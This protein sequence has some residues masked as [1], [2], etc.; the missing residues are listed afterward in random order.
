MVTV[1]SCMASLQRRLR[2]RRCAIDFVRQQHV[3]KNPSLLEFEL[4]LFLGRFK[5]DVRSQKI[6]RH[7]IGRKLNST[8]FEVQRV[9]QCPHQHRLAQ[10]RNAL[11]QN[12]SPANQTGQRALDDFVVTDD[13]LAN[14]VA[15]PFEVGTE[16]V[17]L[18]LRFGG[19][20]HLIRLL[21]SC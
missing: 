18:L 7:Q 11:K 5:H 4:L 9:G 19:R 3:C 1:C 2:L 8:E 12:M 13:D 17:A 6:R 14:F 10:P 20:R 16:L 15:K 21:R